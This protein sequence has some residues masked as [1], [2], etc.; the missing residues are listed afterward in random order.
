MIESNFDKSFEDLINNL[1]KIVDGA[2]SG[3]EQLVVQGTQM[4]K[5]KCIKNTSNNG[6]KIGEHPNSIIGIYDKANNT[7]VITTNGDSVLVWH[8]MG[9]GVIGKDS[10]HPD[11]SI[12]ELGW[13]YDVNEHGD[14]GWIYPKGTNEFGWTRGL[15]SSHFMYDTFSELK[16]KAPEIIHIEINNKK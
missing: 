11:P 6:Y 1:D 10:P 13:E 2:A 8:E 7:G 9:T 14:A 3:I 15:R 5:D 16:E 12:M 4:A